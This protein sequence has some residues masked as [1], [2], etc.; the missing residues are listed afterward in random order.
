[1][2]A[3]GKTASAPAPRKWFRLLA[4]L[5]PAL[6]LA[7]LEIILRLTGYG[8]PTSFFL[9]NTKGGQSVLVENP[10][11]GRRFFSKATARTSQPLCISRNKP[12]GSFRIFVFG[13]SAAM[14]DPDPSYGLSRQLERMLRIRH[15][16]K[17]IEVINTGMT[18]INTHVIREIAQ[19]CA[20][21]GGDCWVVYAGNNEVVGPFGA[22]TVFGRQAASRTAVR[23]TL[24]LKST[25]TGQLL[26]GLLNRNREPVEWQGMEMF[27]NQQVTSLDPRLR[28]V[29]Q[30]FAKNLEAV[31]R[32]GQTAGAKVLVSTA[33]VNL[34]DC[35]PFASAHRAGLSPAQLK[36]WE[37]YFAQ[38][39][40]AEQASRRIEALQAYQNATR[41]DP[42]FAELAFR[43]ARC[44]M[45]EGKTEA[46]MADLRLARD[47]D[48][49]RFR[50]DSKENDIIRDV[51]SRSGV[52]LIDSELEFGRG[53]S[54][55]GPG[56]ELFY[57]HVH[58]NFTGTY[59]LA[60]LFVPEIERALFGRTE[61]G[62][63]V[64]ESDLARQLAFTE[65]DRKRIAEE[66]RLRLQ[67]AP[68]ASQSNS[69]ERDR[70]W[71]ETIAG[72]RHTPG[73]SI[74]SYRAA[75]ESTP[76]DY[77]LRA[78]FGA[79][80]EAAGDG[81]G[82]IVQWRE[83]SRLLPHKAEAWYHLGNLAFSAGSYAEAET[84]FREALRREPG[85][86]EAWSGLG[87]C[88]MEQ[89]RANVAVQRFEA[90]LRQN[91]RYT[92][93]RVNLALA[94]SKTGRTVEATAQYRTAL[95][96]DTNSVAARINLGKLLA[97][98]RQYDDAMVLYREA[99]R[100]TPGE[101]VAEH[102]LGNA[103]AAEGHGREAITHYLA[104]LQ[105]RP[106]FVE[107]RYNLSIELSRVG[108]FTQAIDHFAQVA[109]LKP[110][111]VEGRFNYG[112][113]LAKLHRYAE[114][115]DQFKE[116]L[117]LQP[118]YTPAREALDRALRL[119]AKEAT[120]PSNET[121]PPR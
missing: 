77:V 34:R 90:A 88:D 60:R 97:Q 63:A 92:A 40:L 100:I 26:S 67:Q 3:A 98:Q 10:K 117:R 7:L 66:M 81:G 91:P 53:G 70:H 112:I 72:L 78:N 71:E 73:E 44:E 121:G 93:A 42:E 23:A 27:L 74:P 51:A 9:P 5:T 116:V 6:L 89:D 29:Y 61:P 86:P 32:C 12:E 11:F 14:G 79:L 99:L 16:D 105:Q 108:Q 47:L 54:A 49:L 56:E 24:A 4:L 36:E 33:T 18:A 31:V 118:D 106:D 96:I 82:A 48:T 95:K 13:E 69:S 50:A 45:A 114:S 103:L 80:L 120:E 22:G 107:A 75:I 59:Q 41:I 19:D 37:A 15:P 46:A 76:E 64:D 119:Q 58:L 17:R 25:R 111:F 2:H 109:R 115:V 52:P 62:A 39:N 43:R 57:D 110:N 55:G 65:F 1:M 30:N 102:N 85:S 8:Y 68:F 101:P 20:P 83:V 38:G 84:S 28:I 94:L 87:L 113:A 21:L 35:P 104:A